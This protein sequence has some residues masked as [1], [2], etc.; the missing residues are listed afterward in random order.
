MRLAAT[1]AAAT[2]ITTRVVTTLG[3]VNSLEHELGL[4]STKVA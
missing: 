4:L 1:A 2:L 3:I